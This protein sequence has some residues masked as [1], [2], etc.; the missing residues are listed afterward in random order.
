[1]TEPPAERE[2]HLERD[3]H[4]ELAARLEAA[5]LGG[6]EQYRRRQVEA[7]KLLVRDRLKLLLDAEA[8]FEDG[9]LAR[10]EEGLA[11]D[12][13]VTAVGRLAGRTVCVIANCYTGKAGTWGRRTFDKITRMQQVAGE[14]GA[15]L[16]YLIDSAGA[17]IDEQFESY[18]GRHA[19]GNI[20]YNQVQLS[21]RVP[22]VCIMFGPSPAGSAYVPALCD[23]T[24][25]VEGAATAYLGSPR[26]S[27]MATGEK[28]TL[29]E[30]GGARMHCEVSGLGDALV[31]SEHEALGLLRDWLAFFSSSWRQDPE[32]TDA[33]PPAEGPPMHMIIPEREN[34]AFDIH[35]VVRA[36][37]DEGSFV[38]YKAL[39]ARELVT[40]LARLDGWPVG[41]VANQSMHKG[42]V[43][44][45][46]SWDKAARF[47]W[48]C[49]AFNIP[50]LFLVDV[51]GFMIGSVVERQGIIR[52]GAKMLFAVAESRVPRIAVLVRKAYGG[53]YLTMSGSPHGTV[54]RACSGHRQTSPHG[55]QRRGER[56][57]LQPDHGDLRRARAPSLHR[58]RAGQ[59]RG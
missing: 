46:D 26:M 9:L 15:P 23:L 24:V 52:H 32:R 2:V 3:V 12:A 19:W 31:A 21:G 45:P 42:G 29:E 16:I 33:R 37:V 59:V 35:K 38:E 36:L 56:D 14:V 39:F 25:M 41:I 50:L 20:F 7:G 28:V 47:V 11:G 17:R 48:L 58:R 57:A 51:P 27:E 30:I 44:F 5:R 10:S 6:A 54:C 13:V 18:A 22:Q 40:G 43:L 55:P 34:V 1:L 8:D 53:G 4:A 49:N